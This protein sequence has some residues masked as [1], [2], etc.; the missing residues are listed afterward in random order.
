ML[1][2]VSGGISPCGPNG[3]HPPPELKLP[4]IFWFPQGLEID[5]RKLTPPHPDNILIT[6]PHHLNLSLLY[7]P[8]VP[9]FIYLHNENKPL[10]PLPDVSL[11]LLPLGRAPRCSLCCALQTPLGAPAQPPAGGFAGVTLNIPPAPGRA[12]APQSRRPA[13][14]QAARR[15]A[16]T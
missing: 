6:K 5:A 8:H 14:G 12:A 13:G 4:L 2:P 11:L 7:L 15:P 10:A 16:G 3:C 9:P 1:R